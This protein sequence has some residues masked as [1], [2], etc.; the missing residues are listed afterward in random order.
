SEFQILYH[1][2]YGPPLLGAGAHFSAPLRRV[3]PFNAHAAKDVATYADYAGPVRGFVEQVYN[4]HPFA[5]GDGRSMVMLSNAA[6]DRSVS[7]GFAVA[8]LPYRT[9]SQKLTQLD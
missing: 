6:G 9:L 7:M 5:D 8:A 3:T 1:V 2:N 4:L